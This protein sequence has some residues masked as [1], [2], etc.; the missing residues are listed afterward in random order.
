MP[1]QSTPQ[2][3]LLSAQI[4]TKDPEAIARVVATLRANRGDVSTTVNEIGI[5][6][7]TWYRWTEEVAAFAA[8]VAEHT[9]APGAEVLITV[10][11]ET[12]R[13]GEWATEKGLKPRTLAMRLASGLTPAQA[14][15]AGALERRP[16]KKSRK[17]AK[18]KPKR[19]AS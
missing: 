5:K 9:R 6:H 2:T 12:K 17:T 4:R 10:G 19:F 15:T 13:L 3:R 14:L 16:A 8:A 7:R 18:R 11:K 1:G